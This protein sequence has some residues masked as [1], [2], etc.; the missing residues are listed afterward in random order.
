[1][2]LKNSD[3]KVRTQ[4]N[5]ENLIFGQAFVRKLKRPKFVVLNV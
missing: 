2:D 4:E 5:S 3:V 1:M